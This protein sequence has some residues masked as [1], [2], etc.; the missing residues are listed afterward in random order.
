MPSPAVIVKRGISRIVET[1]ASPVVGHADISRPIMQH[2]TRQSEISL[3]IDSKLASC[4]LSH[5]QEPL[6]Y[7]SR[8]YARQHELGLSP[9]SSGYSA[10]YDSL[11]RTNALPRFWAKRHA[12]CARRRLSL[13]RAL[14]YLLGHLTPSA[15]T[16]SSRYMS[17]TR[18][19]SYYSFHFPVIIKPQTRLAGCDVYGQPCCWRTASNNTMPTAVARF[20]LRVPCIG[21]Q[22]QRSLF[23]ASKLSGRPFV[24]GPNTRKSWG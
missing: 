5:S 17:K 6:C 4:V 7:E 2:V 8:C 11:E 22:M 16:Q 15:P 24:S 9:H 23:A 13:I 14:L 3:P 1:S 12:H 19:V 20:R 21:M 18:Y 10:K